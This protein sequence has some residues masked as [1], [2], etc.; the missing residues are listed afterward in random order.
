MSYFTLGYRFHGGYDSSGKGEKG[1]SVT[2]GYVLTDHCLTREAESV[3]S[4]LPATH[5]KPKT[6][7]DAV[8]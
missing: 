6:L 7:T 5:M 2:L 8:G 1:F 4:T 3:Y